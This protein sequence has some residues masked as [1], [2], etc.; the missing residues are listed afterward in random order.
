MTVLWI[1]ITHKEIDRQSKR[2]ACLHNAAL[3]IV[4]YVIRIATLRGKLLKILMTS[5]DLFLFRKRAR[6]ALGL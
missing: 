2:S 5:D 4:C 1:I 3:Y 6:F